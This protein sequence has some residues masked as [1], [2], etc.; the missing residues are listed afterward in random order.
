MPSPIL[1]NTMLTQV[2]IVLALV[3][4]NLV[5][6]AAAELDSLHVSAA[7]QADNLR[8]RDPCRYAAMPRPAVLID[9]ARLARLRTDLADPANP[10]TRLYQASIKT[11]ALRYLD[12]PIVVPELGGWYHDFFCRTPDG[13][14]LEIPSDQLFREDAPARCPT[15]GATYLDDKI[16]AAR[17]YFQHMWLG[18]AVRDLG[19]VYALEGDRRAAAKAAEILERYADVFIPRFGSPKGGILR[20]SVVTAGAMIPFAEGYDLIYDTLSATQQTR[21]EQ[22]FLLPAAFRLSRCGM[23][24][25]GNWGGWHLSAMG[26]IGYAT[27]HQRLIDLAQQQ[28]LLQLRDE[29]GDDGLWPESVHTY[30]FFTADGYLS[31]AVAAANHGDDLFTREAKP[32][33]SI[34]AMFTRVIPYAY[35]DQS[36]PAINDGW[37]GSMLPESLYVTANHLHPSPELS[38]VIDALRRH[39]Q[40]L[41]DL[42]KDQRYRIVLYDDPRPATAT[43]PAHGSTD[44]SNIGIAVLRQTDV[45]DPGMLTF[46]YGRFLNHGH[47]DRMGVTLFSHGQVVA[48][49]YGTTGYGVPLSGFLQGSFAHNTVVIDGKNQPRTKRQSPCVLVETPELTVAAAS[50]D[51]MAAGVRWLRCVFLTKSYAVISDRLDGDAPHRFDWLFHAEGARLDLEGTTAGDDGGASCA[52]AF[53]TEV[54]TRRAEAG[55][56]TARWV[57]GAH[58]GLTADILSEPGH[59]L[60]TGLMATPLAR[61]V[62]LLAHRQQGTSARFVAVLRLRQVTD[63]AASFQNAAGDRIVVTVPDPAGGADTIDLGPARV[64]VRTAA[65]T[66]RNID[67]STAIPPLHP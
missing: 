37:F 51:E 65:G 42:H 47:L 27:R 63:L 9:Q 1:R 16:R 17:R 66:E 31:L 57:P 67:L 14:R 55:R 5:P 34:L 49:D 54:T 62:P 45:A 18:M 39:P 33:K 6:G 23:A 30:H 19:L 11:N 20:D 28:V 21:I 52:S 36:L 58:G 64:A 13:T 40:E 15:C 53:I 41:A 3:L 22:D 25:H 60:Q 48:A 61:Q 12:R 59:I 4:G 35:P 8:G 38:S 56:I 24:G 43:L 44:F 10:R 26:V 29:L 46:D 32:G 2:L 50:T 7:E